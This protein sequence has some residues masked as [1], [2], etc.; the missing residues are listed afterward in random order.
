MTNGS[1]SFA[2]RRG[3]FRDVDGVQVHD[4]VPSQR[5]N[6]LDNAAEDIH[7]RHAA[8]VFDEIE[9]HAAN[10]ALL[11][12]GVI[13]VGESF[14]D[15][16]DAAITAAARGNGIEHRA[17][18]C[19]VAARLNDYSP[20]DA[21][22]FVQGREALLGSVGRRVGAIGCVG[23]FRGGTEDVTMRVARQCEAS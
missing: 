14:I 3:K 22:N 10:P 13:P 20:L 23:K 17:V 2:E 21:E 18:V 15:D 11:Q 6:A 19:A 7:I 8:Q 5:L 4:E 9:A 12:S 16:G 1:E